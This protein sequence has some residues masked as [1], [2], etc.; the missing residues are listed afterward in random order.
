METLVIETSNGNL[1]FLINTES[2]ACDMVVN[3]LL[4]AHAGCSF[5]FKETWKH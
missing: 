5:Y 2:K 1:E 4:D 3:K